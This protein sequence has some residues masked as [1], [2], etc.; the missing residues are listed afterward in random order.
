MNANGT[1]ISGLTR[2]LWVKWQDTKATW[3]DQK[4]KEFEDRYLFDLLASVDKT[5][6]TI[7]Q[8]DKM[9]TKIRK[10]CE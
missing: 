2:E 5:V 1:R 9:L 10:D 7:E 6:S 4:S 8:V 3:R